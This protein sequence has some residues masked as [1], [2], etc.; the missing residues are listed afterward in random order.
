MTLIEQIKQAVTIE[1]CLSHFG[2]EVPP[3]GRD[4][5]MVPCPWHEDKTPSMAVYRR[6]NRAWCYSC[7]RGGDTLDVTAL[8]IKRDIKE[9]V[10]YWANRLGLSTSKPDPAAVR[11]MEAARE[12]RRILAVANRASL[13]AEQ[14]IPRPRD[15]ALL[16]MFDYIYETKG[17][18]DQRYMCVEDRAGLKAYLKALG[19]WRGFAFR[20]LGTAHVDVSL[21]ELGEREEPALGVD[22]VP[23]MPEAGTNNRQA[24]AHDPG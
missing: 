8:L 14:S 16:D 15:P 13:K 4:P 1:A 19:V 2:M 17:A 5:V 9:A 3:R 20:I 24:V 10:H 22:I 7:A 21:T 23:R 6:A 11:E 18:I 12:R